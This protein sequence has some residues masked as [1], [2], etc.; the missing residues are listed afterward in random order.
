MYQGT[1]VEHNAKQYKMDC[2]KSI[3][4]I[5]VLLLLTVVATMIKCSDEKKFEPGQ[6]YVYYSFDWSTILPG[7]TAPKQ[8]RYCFYAQDGGSVI[9]MDNEVGDLT[10][11]LPPAHYKVLIFNYDADNIQF[12]NI[13]DYDKAEAYI[14]QTKANDGTESGSIPLYGIA[15]E[16]LNIC[17]GENAPVSFKPQPLVRQVSINI[18]LK[19]ME[20]VS[21]CKGSISGVATTLNL[22]R[23]SIVSGVTTDLNFKTI[24]SEEGRKANVMVLGK[25]P[26][27]EDEKPEAPTH[28]VTLDLTFTDGS[29]A[30][31]S[32]DVGNSIENTEGNNVNLEI[33]ATV[34]PGPTFTLTINHWEVAPGDSLII[35]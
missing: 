19:G 7:T 6:G 33:E 8:L 15:C 2:K 10:F 13:T 25:A 14:P 17:S 20:Q 31:T 12:R 5:I 9:M 30:S 28:M 23:Q 16:D 29:T 26:H 4:A 3:S 34:N 27:K 24:P 22:S 35:D 18:A 32:I 21:E 1:T 11:T